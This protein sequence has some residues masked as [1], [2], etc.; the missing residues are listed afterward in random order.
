MQTR[1]ATQASPPS[2]QKLDQEGDPGPDMVP[3]CRDWPATIL[4]R[5]EKNASYLLRTANVGR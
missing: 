5:Q 2:A 1:A 3:S 4:H